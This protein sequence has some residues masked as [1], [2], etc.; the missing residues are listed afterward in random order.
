M[1]WP[2]IWA[3]IKLVMTVLPGEVNLVALENVAWQ[4][5]EKGWTKGAFLTAVL[6]N[7]TEVFPDARSR[8]FLIVVVQAMLDLINAAAFKPGVFP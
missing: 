7:A 1:L 8:P 5:F 6:A 4:V 2:E 3:A